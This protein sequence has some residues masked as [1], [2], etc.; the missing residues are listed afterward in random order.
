MVMISPKIGILFLL[1]LI[2]MV[3]P[4]QI[5][6]MPEDS[7][8]CVQS[9]LN[10]AN[11]DAGPADG[12][13][14]KRTRKAVKAFEDKFGTISKR[15]L[16]PST[17]NVFCRKIGLIIPDLK[18]FWPSNSGW[19]EVVFANSVDQKF[20]SD[21]Q[22]SLS[23]AV[24]AVSSTVGVE[25][26][27]K[28]IIVI[29]ENA[30]ELL[31]LVKEH[32]PNSIHKNNPFIKASCSSSRKITGRAHQGIIFMCRSPGAQVGKDIDETWLDYLV[33]HELLHL[34]QFQ[35]S[36]KPARWQGET[37]EVRTFG[38][39]WLAEGV[40]EAFSNRLGWGTEIWALRELN[41]KRLDKKLPD[42]AQL[43]KRKAAQKGQL[44]YNAGAVAA[45]DLLD[46]HGFDT[47]MKM[48]DLLGQGENWPNVFESTFGMS[49][50]SFY[51]WYLNVK[52]FENDGRAIR[53]LVR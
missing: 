23:K 37:E 30:S 4:T 2:L 42:L 29:A 14:G 18:E 16:S 47:V 24:T 39:F 36:G 51:K 43:E 33:S 10:A 7:I 49:H 28:D 38:P 21:L 9:Q 31:S 44:V 17:A 1:T 35:L 22:R 5:K 46:L 11:F 53:K 20:R 3:L 19:I 12:Q 8:Q 52:R 32:S 25:V 6:A 34:V 26:A 15:K 27:G 48:Y 45:V 50:A 41:Y 40:A 13:I